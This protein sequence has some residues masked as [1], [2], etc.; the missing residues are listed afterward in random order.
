MPVTLYDDRGRQ[1]IVGK[2]F[3]HEEKEQPLVRERRDVFSF[4]FGDAELLQY[5]LSGIYIVYGDVVLSQTPRLYFNLDNERELIEMHFTLAGSGRMCN[6]ATGQEFRFTANEH[7]LHYTP[8]FTGT[9]EYNKTDNYKFFEIH[10]TTRFFAELAKDSSPMLMDF[11]EKVASNAKG[12]VHAGNLPMTAA[13]HQC[14]QDIIHC[15]YTGGLKLMF[16]QSKCIELLTMQV[17]LYE[18]TAAKTAR[19]CKSDYDK[20]CIHFAKDY[21]LQHALQPPSLHELAR[22]AGI[23]EFKLKQ[24]FREV[25]DNTVFGYLAEYKLAQAR[26]LLLGGKLPIKEVAEQLGYSSVQHFSNAFKKKYGVS[27]GKAK[28]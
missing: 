15:R 2:M 24:G 28:R 3:P 23:N 21:L 5:S 7:S 9:G 17:Q 16:L 13:M 22:L 11:A 27:P 20:D 18:D 26:E 8:S 25:F 10:F 12:E 14:I 6:L 19:I 1:Y 4:P